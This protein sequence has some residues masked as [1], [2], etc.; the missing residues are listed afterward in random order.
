MRQFFT[1]VASAI[2]NH[3]AGTPYQQ[4]VRRMNDEEKRILQRGDKPEDSRS[5]R[6]LQNTVERMEKNGGTGH[7][8]KRSPL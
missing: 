3:F 5:Y 6:E 2:S 7:F 4:A 8:P 1:K